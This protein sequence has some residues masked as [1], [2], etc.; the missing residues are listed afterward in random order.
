MEF[1]LVNDS[2]DPFYQTNIRYYVC[3]NC[4]YDRECKRGA[5]MPI[6]SAL[7]RYILRWHAEQKV[8]PGYPLPGNWDDQPL[9]FSNLMATAASTYNRVEQERITN[10]K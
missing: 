7:S 5:E 3:K 9:W 1:A 6:V 2:A 8:V 10:G 4:A